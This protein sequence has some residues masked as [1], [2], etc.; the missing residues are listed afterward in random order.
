[1]IAIDTTILV[2]AT[3][4]E[5]P[6]H[7]EAH[8]AVTEISASGGGRW[9]IPWPCAHE[10]LSAVT[11]QK[12]H[13]SATPQDLAMQFLKNCTLFPMFH[14]IGEGA[15]YLE[16]IDNLLASLKASSG[17]IHDAKI[18]AIYLHHGVSE[19]WTADRDFSRFPKRK[20]RNPLVK[21]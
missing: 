9:A 11:N 10:F 17:M 5:Y 16:I 12:I 21:K 15:G 1:M 2:Y 19:L 3:R 8:R 14:F 18:A 13:R 20:T 6:F 4:T 7:N